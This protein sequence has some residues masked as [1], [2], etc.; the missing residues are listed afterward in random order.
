MMRSSILETF[1]HSLSNNHMLYHW[2]I[3]YYLWQDMIKGPA[4]I[5]NSITAIL[6]L[7]HTCPHRYV[8]ILG[9]DLIDF[10]GE[11]KESTLRLCFSTLQTPYD[12]HILWGFFSIGRKMQQK[13]HHY[14]CQKWDKEKAPVKCDA[15]FSAPIFA[16]PAFSDELHVNRDAFKDLSELT[17]GVGKRKTLFK[18]FII[19]QAQRIPECCFIWYQ[20]S[21]S[22]LIQFI[23]QSAS[24]RNNPTQ[25]ASMSPGAGCEERRP[26]VGAWSD[27]P[28]AVCCVLL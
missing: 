26:P 19:W 23:M 6:L 20:L 16:L 13:I 11:I 12:G 18:V 28:W 22:E 21:L 1:I 27:W 4:G 9:I 24:S 7:K 17:I 3:A 2:D 14:L 15:W 25:Y 5:W 8:C 10:A